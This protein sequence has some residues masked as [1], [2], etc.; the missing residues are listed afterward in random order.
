[1]SKHSELAKEFF[2]KGYNCSQSVVV[3]FCDVMKLE[4][5]TALK[6]SSSFGGGMG[7]LR[8]VCGAVSGMLIVLGMLE[9]YS[10]PL[11]KTAK[12]KHY[13]LIQSIAIRFKKEKKSLICR[14]LLGLSDEI[15]SYIHEERSEEFYKKRP[16]AEIVEYAAIILDEYIQ[17]KKLEENEMM[18]IAVASENKMVTDHFG[19]CEGF[20]IFETE[21][22]KILKSE[23]IANPGHRPGFLPDFLADYGVDIVISGGM[24]GGAVE[25]FNKRNIKVI[26][27]AKGDANGVVESFLKGSLKSEGS[28]CHE[29]QHHD[30]CK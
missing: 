14:E 12:A 19:H 11:D 2:K 18:K 23:T 17:N 1:M 29:H 25:L 16:C 7:R 26:L 3:A 10:D 27:G 22:D 30:E 20:I 8:E 4:E 28:I 5:E 15:Q 13:K 21:N 24:G 6:I 9:G